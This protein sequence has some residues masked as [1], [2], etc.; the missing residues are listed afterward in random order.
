MWWPPAAAAP[1][2]PLCAFAPVG[3]VLSLSCP[4]NQ[5]I[6]AVN[7]ASFGAPIG[8]CPSYSAS[9]TCTSSSSAAVVSAACLGDQS[10]AM[11]ATTDIFGSTPCS[12]SVRVQAWAR[13]CQVIWEA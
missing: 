3:S 1:P 11:L 4:A 7:F 10:C 9:P 5:V 2:T 8:S 13:L 12:G 6:S